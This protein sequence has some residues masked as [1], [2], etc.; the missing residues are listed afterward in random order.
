MLMIKQIYY[1]IKSK[2]VW[3]FLSGVAIASG[4]AIEMD[5]QVNPYEK[6]ENRFE[7]QLPEKARIA[8]SENKP[9]L[10]L[11]KWDDECF[12]KV[13]YPTTKKGK[14]KRKPLTNKL[15]WVEKDKKIHMYPLENGFEYEIILNEKPANNIITLGLETQGLVFYYQP[16]LTQEEIDEGCFR[17]ENVIGSYA[18]YHES[19]Q[20]DYSQMGGK[21][22]K[23]GKAFHI[24]RPKIIDNAGIEVWG[25]LNIIDNL[26]TVE[27]PQ[28]FLDNAVYPIRRAA[29]LEFGYTTNGGSGDIMGMN[30]LDGSV[31]EAPVNATADNIKV[32]VD[33]DTG[34]TRRFKAVLVL[35][36]NLNIVD[37]GV[38]SIVEKADSSGETLETS[39]FGTPP[40]L[41]ANTNYVLSFVS[42]YY[43]IEIQYDTGDAD[44]GHHDTSNDYGTPTNP[45]DA[46]HST[47][48][49]SIYCTYTAGGAEEEPTITPPVIRF[50]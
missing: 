27:I 20:G 2:L 38:G 41:T 49:Y 22:Y 48:K 40:S 45:T 23:A 4:G 34:F 11:G 14:V 5:R 16:E 46:S 19:K 15:E 31:F 12:V 10:Y 29:G 17:P 32:Y 43:G 50:E 30:H 28:D 13:S 47:I 6:I 1:W 39:T 9:E 25:K 44:Q 36:S 3:L 42:Q 37:D 8:I 18:V 33:N 21:N 24:Y 7:I 26:L 35:H